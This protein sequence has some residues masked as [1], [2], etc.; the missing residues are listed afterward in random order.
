VKS[1]G[2]NFL[3]RL[4][5]NSRMG[6][7]TA[8]ILRLLVQLKV[9]S[10]VVGGWGEREVSIVPGR[11]IAPNFPTQQLELAKKPEPGNIFA[12]NFPEAQD[13]F[14]AP[15]VINAAGVWGDRIGAMVGFH[16]PITVSRHQIRLIKRPAA[17]RDLNGA[18]WS[19]I[20]SSSV[21]GSERHN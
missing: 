18:C 10:A 17:V 14:S 8:G 12:N 9:F 19:V 13:S 11:R 4:G 15:T 7:R 1:A 21:S 5:T 3:A 16:I 2:E 20:R 6:R